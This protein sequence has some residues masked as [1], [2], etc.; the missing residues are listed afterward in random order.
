MHI[1]INT[2]TH[3]RC[4]YTLT[5]RHKDI[6][7]HLQTFGGHANAADEGQEQVEEKVC[8][9]VP[10]PLRLELGVQETLC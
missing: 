2:H 9:V 3:L 10:I 1:Q 7:V 8:A 5:Y 6:R 4:T